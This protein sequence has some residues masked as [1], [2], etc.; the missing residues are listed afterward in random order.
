MSTNGQKRL[1]HRAVPDL[2]ALPRPLYARSESLQR[3]TTTLWHSHP[4]AQLSYAISGVLAVHTHSGRF[5]APPQRAILVPPD[6]PHAVISSPDTEM[7]SLYIERDAMPWRADQCAVLEIN[8]LTRELINQ[9][10]QIPIEYD[11]S[12]ADG[13][14]V[15]VLLDQLTAARD[16]GLY[17]PW[18]EDSRLQQVCQALFD[19][20]ELALT[21]S[22]WSAQLDCSEKTL[23]RLFQRDT[24]LSFR[25]WRQRLRLL[26]ALPMLERGERVTDIALACG[27]DSTSAFIAAFRKHIGVTPSQFAGGGYASPLRAA[28]SPG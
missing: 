4:W 25:A 15:A 27:Y 26:S 21:L 3:G 13:R 16:T 10:G 28:Q 14:L 11:E 12:G 5:L 23:T 19:N 20:P 8:P 1:N 7:R 2:P 6:L 9:F 18:P 24:G 22:D 17:L